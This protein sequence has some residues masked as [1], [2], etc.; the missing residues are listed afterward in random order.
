MR[1]PASRGWAT[2]QPQAGVARRPAGTEPPTGDLE[3][4]FQNP[5]VRPPV[6]LAAWALRLD[7]SSESRSAPSTRDD[8]SSPRRSTCRRGTRRDRCRDGQ[9]KCPLHFDLGESANAPNGVRGGTSVGL[10]GSQ[11]HRRPTDRERVESGAC[12]SCGSTSLIECAVH[13]GA[14]WVHEVICRDCREALE[15]VSYLSHEPVR[16]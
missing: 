7:D 11:G 3:R 9:N 14:S 16:S 1:C 4:S 10:K 15:T 6:Q 5:R 13:D 8:R 12:P 2:Q